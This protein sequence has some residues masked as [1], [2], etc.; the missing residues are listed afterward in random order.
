MLALGIL[1]TPTPDDYGRDVSLAVEWRS[2][3]TTM[4]GLAGMLQASEAVLAVVILAV[5]LSVWLYVHRGGSCSM[6]ELIAAAFGALFVAAL[7][8]PIYVVSWLFTRDVREAVRGR[9]E[10]SFS[11]QP[12]PRRAARA[13]SPE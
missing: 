6:V 11:S 5:A 9:D 10:D 7:F 4:V 12:S 3:S 8:V 2:P 13:D 1:A